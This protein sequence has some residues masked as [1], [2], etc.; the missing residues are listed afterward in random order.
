MPHPT[1]DFAIDPQ[2]PLTRGPLGRGCPVKTT[3]FTFFIFFIN[4]MIQNN[5]HSVNAQAPSCSSPRMSHPPQPLPQPYSPS[6]PALA[7]GQSLGG[8]WGTAGGRKRALDRQ[9]WFGLGKRLGSRFLKTHFY[10]RYPAIFPAP[11]FK[12]FPIA[13]LLSVLPLLPILW[14]LHNFYPSNIHP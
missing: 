11:F 2:A 12:S 3:C 6:S 4:Q 5:H 13:Q 10:T 7:Q 9:L 14:L 1:N 8:T